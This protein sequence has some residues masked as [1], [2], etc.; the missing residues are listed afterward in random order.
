MTDWTTLVESTINAIS[1]DSIN[2]RATVDVTCVWGAKERKRIIANGVDDLLIDEMR[3]V[4]IIDRVIEYGVDNLSNNS[5]DVSQHLSVLMWG[6]DATGDDL[7][8]PLL[9]NKLALIEN[10]THKLLRIEPVYGPTIMIL[11]LDFRLDVIKR[12]P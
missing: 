7:D 4:G 10:G 5:H 3:L 1:L 8:S 6:R 11:A 9:K 12:E 2:K